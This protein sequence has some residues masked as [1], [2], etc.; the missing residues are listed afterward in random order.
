MPAPKKDLEKTVDGLRQQ[1]ILAETTLG[2]L[3]SKL[4]TAEARLTGSPAP[5]SGLDLLWKAALSKSRERSS[6]HLCRIEWNRVPKH[7]RPPVQQAVTALKAWNRS[8]EWKKDGNAFAPGLHRFIKNRM[9]EDLPEGSTYDPSARY[10]PTPQAPPIQ[11]T[12]EDEAALAEF[13]KLPV[14]RMQS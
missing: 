13:L 3:R 12:A 11:R 6:K 9:W 5:E 1:V 4:A 10:R 14:K 8:E 7:D 2:H